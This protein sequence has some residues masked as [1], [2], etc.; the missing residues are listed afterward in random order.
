MEFSYYIKYNNEYF[1]EPVYYHGV[2]AVKKFVSMLKEDTIEIEKFIKEKEEKYKDVKSMIDLECID[3]LSKHLRE[4][5]DNIKSEFEKY[6]P[7]IR[8]I[9]YNKY[10]KSVSKETAKHFPEYKLDLITRKGVYPYDYMDSEEK[11]KET[12]LA[13]KIFL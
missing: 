4:L 5:P 8:A 2:D 9:K 6:P 13:P 7:K 12:E 10:L 3:A 1:K 11:Y